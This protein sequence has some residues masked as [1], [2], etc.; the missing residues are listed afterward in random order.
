MENT[1]LQHYL[2]RIKVRLTIAKIAW[3]VSLFLF[4]VSVITL[5]VGHSYSTAITQDP[6]AL[7]RLIIFGLPLLII[8]RDKK[9]LILKDSQKPDKEIVAKAALKFIEKVES[10]ENKL[11]NLAV[12][13]LRQYI[14][15][16]D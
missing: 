12:D 1:L 14:N 5:F 7:V 11:N 8:I 10:E 3:W 16:K 2:K 6:I 13:E 9:E 4:S 15:E